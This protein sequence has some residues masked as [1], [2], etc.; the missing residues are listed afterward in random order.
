MREYTDKLTDRTKKSISDFVFY[1][2]E[3]EQCEGGQLYGPK[4][5]DYHF[6]HFVVKGE[7]TLDIQGRSYPIHRDQLFIVPAGEVSIYRASEVNPWKYCWIGFLGIQSVQFIN[8]LMRCGPERYVQDCQDASYYEDQIR[9]ILDLSGKRVSTHLRSNGVMYNLIGTLLDELGAD[10]PKGMGISIPYQARQYMDLHY[11]DSLQI[12]DVAAA[13]GVH[14]N[15][16]ANVF[17]EQ[18]HMTPKQYLTKLKLDKA[19]ELL[20]FTE[21]PIYIVANSVGFSDPLAFSKFFRRMTGASPSEYRVKQ[22]AD[23]ELT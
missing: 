22:E 3:I 16:L 14:V 15:Y 13:V 20:L 18:Y 10:D 9:S 23:N 5:R 11:H 1:N 2:C 12:A 7:G 4:H 21:H 6:I 8:S 17:Q 19:K